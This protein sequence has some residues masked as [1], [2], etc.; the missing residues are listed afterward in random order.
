MKSKEILIAIEE[1]EK[2]KKRKEEV[3][4]ARKTA[5]DIEKTQM[6]KELEKINEQIE[7]YAGLIKDMKKDI[8]PPSVEDILR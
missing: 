6:K 1:L 3:K 7:Y 4:N 2:W 5:S 8:K